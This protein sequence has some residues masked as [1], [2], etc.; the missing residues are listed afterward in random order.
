MAGLRIFSDFA[1]P[2]CYLAKAMVE[3]T[4][5]GLSF[6]TIWVPF[7]LHPEIPY[8]GI[9]LTDFY[10]GLDTAAFTR[11]INLKAAPFSIHFCETKRMVNSGRAIRAAEFARD[12]GCF[13]IFHTAVFEALFTRNQNI[14]D[15]EIL[16]KIAAEQ[17]L[18]PDAMDKAIDSHIYESRLRT[19]AIEAAERNI[20]ITPSF[21]VPGHPPFAGLPSE[22]KM[23]FLLK[24]AASL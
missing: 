19:A 23:L 8:D 13:D 17:G 2:Y 18:D 1:C 3:K 16:R 15:P 7:E 5:K 24:Q 4:G 22:E 11:K 10:P 20:R 14:G 12:A 9:A 21:V 6:S